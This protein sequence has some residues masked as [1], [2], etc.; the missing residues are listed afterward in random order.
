MSTF[1][2]PS[3]SSPVGFLNPVFHKFHSFI[4]AISRKEQLLRD[5][6]PEAATFQPENIEEY[7]LKICHE[8]EQDHKVIKIKSLYLRARKETKVARAKIEIAI[9]NLI[10]SKKIIPG[11]FLHIQSVLKNAARKK[12]YDLIA[13]RPAFQAL[14]LKTETGLGAKILAWHLKQLLDFKHIKQVIF[15]NKLL[16]AQPNQDDY[17]A[18][19]YYVISRNQIDRFILETLIHQPSLKSFLVE[20]DPAKRTTYLYHINTLEQAGLIEIAN[21]ALSLY[22]ITNVFHDPISRVFQKFF[23]SEILLTKS[24]ET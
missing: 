19:A 14:D 2:L 3:S 21:P 15:G 9:N 16:F 5:K 12:I 4:L 8:F 11:R 20:K 7:L 6:S 24:N 17:E 22:Q 23:P 1:H 10:L 13:S 18:I